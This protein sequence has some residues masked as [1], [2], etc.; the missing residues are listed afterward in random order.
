MLF[1]LTNAPT[2]F[3][4]VIN[5]ALHK[6]LDIF[7]IAYINNVLIYINR[8]EQKYIKHVRKCYK[9]LEETIKTKQLR[10]DRGNRG[11]ITRLVR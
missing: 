9:R 3:Q 2:T 1:K 11:A 7:Y 4:L 5:K 10:L 6:Y 8:L